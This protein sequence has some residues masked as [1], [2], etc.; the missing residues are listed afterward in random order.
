MAEQGANIDLPA[1]ERTYSRF[2]G[3]FKYGA[4]FCFL[5]AFLVIFLIT[6]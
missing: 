5:I 2:I 4:I 6:R 3:L 1:H